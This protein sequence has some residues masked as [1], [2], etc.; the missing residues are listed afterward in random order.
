MK[1]LFSTGFGILGTSFDI[2][3]SP[4]QKKWDSVY[5]TKLHHIFTAILPT[6]RRSTDARDLKLLFTRRI[7]ISKKLQS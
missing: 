1:E 4:G 3:S 7:S 6:L 5:L 2:D